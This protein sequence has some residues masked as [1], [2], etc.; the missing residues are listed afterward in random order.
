M[1]ILSN[2]YTTKILDPCQEEVNAVFSKWI[3]LGFKQRSFFESA[4]SEQHDQPSSKTRRNHNG[5]K[6]QVSSIYHEGS[7]WQEV[8]LYS[9]RA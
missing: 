3:P 6:R 7:D 5:G 4:N 8:L 9:G 1:I 2:H